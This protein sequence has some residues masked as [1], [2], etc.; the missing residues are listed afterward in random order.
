M[1]MLRHDLA[2][3]SRYIGRQPLRLIIRLWFADMPQPSEISKEP[4]QSSRDD[5]IERADDVVND[6]SVKQKKT[7]NGSWKRGLAKVNIF[8]GFIGQSPRGSRVEVLKPNVG[9]FMHYS[10]P[11]NN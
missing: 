9:A 5:E 1:H 3:K 10:C 2:I 4:G 11:R 8:Q 6:S 7:F